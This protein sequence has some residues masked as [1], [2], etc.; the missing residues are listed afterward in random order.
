LQVRDW[1][2]VEDHCR[3]ILSV[4][5]GGK[6]GETYNIGGNRSL[7]NLEV[8]RMVLKATGGPESLIQYVT[9]RP[10]HDRRYALTSEKLTNETGWEPKVQFEDG[11]RDT[12][13]WYRSNPGWVERVRSQAYRDYYAMNYQGRDG[14]YS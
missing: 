1:L 13:E 11:L 12:I 7:S 4:V 10:G 9:D 5:K 3:A 14:K 8:V 6:P 2:F